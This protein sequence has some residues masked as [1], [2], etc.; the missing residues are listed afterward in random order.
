VAGPGR[1]ADGVQG[2][3][4]LTDQPAVHTRADVAIVAAVEGRADERADQPD[5]EPGD[6]HGHQDLQRHG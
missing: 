2:E 4:L 5:P 3:H 6:G 1:I